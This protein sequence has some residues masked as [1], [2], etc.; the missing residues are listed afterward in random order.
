MMSL[1]SIG[2][3]IMSLS[4][5]RSTF[6]NITKTLYLFS[7][8]FLITFLFIKK[9]VYS[10]EIKLTWDSFYEEEDQITGYRAFYREEGQNYNYNNPIWEGTEKFCT[11]S[12]LDDKKIYYFVSRSF[13]IYGVESNDSNEIRYQPPNSEPA[14]VAQSISLYENTPIDIT[15]TAIDTDHDPLTYKIIIQPS[16]GTL[17]GRAPTLTYTPDIDYD[18]SDILGFKVNDGVADSNIAYVSITIYPAEDNPYDDPLAGCK[19]YDDSED[20]NTNGWI[21]YDQDPSGAS[22]SNVFDID[23]QS[24]VIDFKSISRDYC[25]LL[26]NADGS[27]WKNSSQ[28]M[29][30]WSMKYSRYFIVYIDVHTTAGDKYLY[31]TTADYDALGDGHY[32]HHGLG[33]KVT[34]GKWYSFERNLQADLEEAQ[35]GVSIL[36][37]NGFMVYGSGRV[38]DIMLCNTP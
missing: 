28:N 26:R 17:S 1:V 33:S 30:Q 31:Y 36:E 21:I 22:I 35:P 16:H 7:I 25:Y 14:A 3:V 6:I 11:I 34:D 10:F 20:G 38:D 27:K 37:V 15:L 12:N 23:R 9:N 2:A 18:G 5:S 4:F 29:I 13:D 24:R 8:I 32:I 19:V